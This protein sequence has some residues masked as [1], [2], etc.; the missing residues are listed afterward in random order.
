MVAMG[1]GT[2]RWQGTHEENRHH[3]VAAWH[4][5]HLGSRLIAMASWPS[6]PRGQRPEGVRCR[7]DTREPPA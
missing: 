4:Q 5:A 3:R 6:S 7:P 1:E 2:T